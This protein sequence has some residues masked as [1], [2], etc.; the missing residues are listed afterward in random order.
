MKGSVLLS[1]SRKS[2]WYLF[3]VCKSL[4]RIQTG[5]YNNFYVRIYCRWLPH[6]RIGLEN[7]MWVIPSYNAHIF[8]GDGFSSSQL[9]DRVNLYIHAVGL[10][11]LERLTR[12]CLL[13]QDTLIFVNVC[14]CVDVWY[15]VLLVLGSQVPPRNPMTSV[16]SRCAWKSIKR[17][18]F[19]LTAT[20]KGCESRLSSLGLFGGCGPRA[21][22]WQGIIVKGSLKEKKTK[23]H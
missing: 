16:L 18:T 9:R 8:P 14:V 1:L 4:F 13:N 11:I 21:N 22:R 23:V 5:C 19:A 7:R 20:L 15:V 10:P 6:W 2:V 12:K 3:C 17:R